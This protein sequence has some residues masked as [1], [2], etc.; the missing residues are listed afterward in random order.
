MNLVDE[1]NRVRL[2]LQGVEHLLDAFL[3]VAP[4]AG[5]RDER[6]K[7]EG[8]EAGVLER[9]RHPSLVNA[10]GQALGQRRLSDAWL[11]DEEGIV[12]PPPAEHMHHAVEFGI[13]P[14]QRVD[15]TGGRARGQIGG[16]GLERLRVPPGLRI[17]VAPDTGATVGHLPAQHPQQ[18]QP[19][20]T[21]LPQEV[22]GMAVGFL[23]QE[24][25][26]GPALYL[27]RRR[28]C[29]VEHGTLHHPVEADGRL[30]LDGRTAGH[31]DEGTG[32]HLVE[33]RRQVGQLDPARPQRLTG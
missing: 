15:L 14:N 28:G 22:G 10:Q 4:I 18:G 3:E 13:A 30:R 16:V 9:G 1:Q 12:L 21:L 6:P 17:L 5:A 2:L 8:V 24:H 29:G 26:E 31:R 20:D 33:R 7:I 19:V 11:T 27:R 23:Q 25:Q 32:Q